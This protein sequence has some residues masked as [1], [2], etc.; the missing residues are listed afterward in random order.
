MNTVDIHVSALIDTPVENLFIYSIQIKIWF[1]WIL[2]DTDCE[3]PKQLCIYVL[4]YY[5]I[6]TI[7]FTNDT[8]TLWECIYMFGLGLKKYRE[9]DV[10]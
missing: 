6:L 10:I 2:N 1:I 9:E 8:F 5:I 3:S 4:Y 7:R